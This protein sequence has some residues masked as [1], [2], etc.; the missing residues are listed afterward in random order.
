MRV[1]IVS[2]VLLAIFVAAP[3]S[4]HAMY[5]SKGEARGEAKYFV[6]ERMKRRAYEAYDTWFVERGSRCSRVNSL[7]VE[8][9]FQYV[10]EDDTDDDGTYYGCED[11]VRIRET[12]TQY[13]A[14]FS[15]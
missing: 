5:L 2:A 3:A 7:I 10:D 15:G 11:T 13:L 8:C 12:R 9:D 1:V 4:A 14:H 6:G